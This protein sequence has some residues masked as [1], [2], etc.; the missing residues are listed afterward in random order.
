MR[1]VSVNIETFGGE[2]IWQIWSWKIKTASETAEDRKTRMVLDADEFVGVDHAQC[3][4]ANRELH[5]SLAR[6]TGRDRQRS[7]GARQD[8]TAWTRGANCT[9]TTR[10]ER[11]GERSLCNANACAHK[12]CRT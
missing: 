6:Y 3:T 11:W 7:S 12:Q 10:E 9:P 5:S 4:K 2:E 8:L 1:E